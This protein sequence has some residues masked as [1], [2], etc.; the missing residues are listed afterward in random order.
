MKLSYCTY[1]HQGDHYMM[2][3]VLQ[4]YYYYFLLIHFSIRFILLD[5]FLRG[6]FSTNIWWVRRASSFL[7]QPRASYEEYFQEIF[8]SKILLGEYFAK[9]CSSTN[10]SSPNISRAADFF[11]TNIRGYGGYKQTCRLTGF[12]PLDRQP[13]RN[14]SH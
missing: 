1:L 5:C 8:L 3:I 10:I 6:I 12:E 13:S 7:E 2:W 14:S 11:P 9:I 4:Y